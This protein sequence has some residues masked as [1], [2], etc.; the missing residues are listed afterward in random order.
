MLD[1]LTVPAEGS[2]LGSGRCA[3]GAAP[4]TA[5]PAAERRRIAA[6]LLAGEVD[7]LVGTQQTLD[8]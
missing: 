7:I 6:G 4:P 2:L 1:G 8:G 3:P 5:H